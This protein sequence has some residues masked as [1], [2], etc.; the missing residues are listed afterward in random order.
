MNSFLFF[1]V[2]FI[3]GSNSNDLQENAEAKQDQRSFLSL[4]CFDWMDSDKLF[5]DMLTKKTKKREST[6]DWIKRCKKA[7]KI[8]KDTTYTGISNLLGESQPQMM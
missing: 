8:F 3:T 5:K 2:H 4:K 1:L 6:D 7:L